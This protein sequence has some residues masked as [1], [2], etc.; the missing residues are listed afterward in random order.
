M[1]DIVA[2]MPPTPW[3]LHEW[4]KDLPPMLTDHKM[5]T[6]RCTEPADLQSSCLQSSK[7]PRYRPNSGSPLQRDVAPHVV[8][9]YLFPRT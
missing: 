1:Q 7:Q 4:T 6:T 5:I 8:I 2:P 9:V 3:V